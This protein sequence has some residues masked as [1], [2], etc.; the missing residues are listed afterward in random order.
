MAVKYNDLLLQGRGLQAAGDL[1]GAL[2][3]FSNA[4]DIC[5]DDTRLHAKVKKI[6]LHFITK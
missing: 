4:L 5:D 6:A 2:Q 1:G 3:C